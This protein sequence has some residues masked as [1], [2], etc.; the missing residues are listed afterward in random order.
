MNETI[1][2]TFNHEKF[3]E[4]TVLVINNEAWFIVDNICEMLEI[5]DPE[6]I[7][8]ALYHVDDEDRMFFCSSDILTEFGLFN[9]VLEL[10]TTLAKEFLHWITSEVL[11][12]I[13]AELD[14]ITTDKCFNSDNI[15]ERLSRLEECFYVITD[16]MAQ[17]HI[18]LNKV[19]N[20][21]IT[22]STKH[23]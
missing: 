9:F 13:N 1:K 15:E 3:G 12:C 19:L 22:G 5:S 16:K 23:C 2:V 4:I 14:N 18:T 6:A 17:D 8:A 10:P 11:P 21:I 20:H 7:I